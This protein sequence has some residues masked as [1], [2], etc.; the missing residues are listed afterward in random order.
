MKRPTPRWDQ[1]FLNFTACRDPDWL[2][3]LWDYSIKKDLH[4]LLWKCWLCPI[5]I[6]SWATKEEAEFIEMRLPRC[7]RIIAKG[8]DIIHQIREIDKEEGMD[9]F[10][11][12]KRLT[13]KELEILRAYPAFRAWGFYVMD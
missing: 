10:N 9:R 5:L 2:A 11:F 4:D 7:S 3:D 12:W 8:I 6:E 1:S 13:D